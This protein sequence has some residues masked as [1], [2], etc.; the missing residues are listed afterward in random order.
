L[1]TIEVVF[2]EG[3]NHVLWRK[4]VPLKFNIFIWRLFLNR[5]ATKMDMFKRNILGYLDILCLAACDLV[6]NQ[7]HLFFSCVGYRQLIWPLTFGWLGIS[8]T[9]HSSFLDHSIQFGG[10][11]GFSNKSRLAFN[12]ILILVLFIIWKDHNRRFFHNKTEQLISSL[13]KVKL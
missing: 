6:E 4:Q 12:I 5:L 1:T 13:T 3:F 10:L 7:D 9:F 2:N 8:T 11:G